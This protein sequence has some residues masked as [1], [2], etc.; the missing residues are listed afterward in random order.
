MY[1]E[2][3][4]VVKQVLAALGMAEA[5]FAAGLWDEPPHESW[6][7]VLAAAHHAEVL[8]K[9]CLAE[10]TRMQLAPLRPRGLEDSTASCLCAQT[11]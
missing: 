1:A 5:L 10:P 4:D 2:C 7:T 9:H 11:A 3:V 8:E 6:A